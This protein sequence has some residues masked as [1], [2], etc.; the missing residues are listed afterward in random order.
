[1]FVQKIA[2]SLGVNVGL[3]PVTGTPLPFVSYGG[4]S[5]VFMAGMVGILIRISRG[6]FSGK[7]G[8]SRLRDGQQWI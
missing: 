3:L 8:N 2:Q 4:S 5:L 7:E 6:N 1:M